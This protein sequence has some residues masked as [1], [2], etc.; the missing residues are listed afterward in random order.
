MYN[1]PPPPYRAGVT[2]KL[3]SCSFRPNHLSAG[4][5][6]PA[7]P[8]VLLIPKRASSVA[9]HLNLNWNNAL[10]NRG[11]TPALSKKRPTHSRAGSGTAL[12]QRLASGWN[13]RWS[14]FW[15]TLKERLLTGING[16]WIG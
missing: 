11:I 7:I 2:P 13:A 8:T 5:N 14:R 1:P 6:K 12:D 3:L 10:A 15:L 16:S 9:A 4:S